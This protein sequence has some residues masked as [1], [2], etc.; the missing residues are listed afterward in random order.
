RNSKSEIRNPISRVY[1][2]ARAGLLDDPFIDAR[3]RRRVVAVGGR[4]TSFAT[5][6]ETVENI[7][8][9]LVRRTN[10]LH[11]LVHPLPDFR[12]SIARLATK[13]RHRVDV[14]VA[15]AHLADRTDC[16]R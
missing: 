10:S 1:T 11:A 3:R 14:C 2:S 12:T 5:S 8:G 4:P 16:D 15:S 9:R 7:A 6:R 13:A